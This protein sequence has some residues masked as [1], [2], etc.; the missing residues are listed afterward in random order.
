MY[1][2]LFSPV[3]IGR[4]EIKNRVAMTAMGVNLAAA[5]GGRQ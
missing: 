3:Q 5:G 2:N 1:A 4:L